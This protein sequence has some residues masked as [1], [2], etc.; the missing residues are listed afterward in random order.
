MVIGIWKGWTVGPNGHLGMHFTDGAVCGPLTKR[1]TTVFISCRTDDVPIPVSTGTD[2]AGA[3]AGSGSGSGAIPLTT[4]EIL[5]THSAYVH[6][7]HY[8]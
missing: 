1:S 5:Q 7:H 4:D 2:T 8:Y 6:S 3:G